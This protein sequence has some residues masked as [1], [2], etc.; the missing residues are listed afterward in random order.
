MRDSLLPDCPRLQEDPDRETEL[1]RVCGDRVMSSAYTGG[2]RLPV[3]LLLLLL[4]LWDE[5]RN[6][7]LLGFCALPE[8][9]DVLGDAE[10]SGGQSAQWRG[11][12]EYIPESHWMLC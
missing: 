4:L 2:G 3:G 5:V 7:K 10:V 6:R 11:F 8:G 9:G 12:I 1:T